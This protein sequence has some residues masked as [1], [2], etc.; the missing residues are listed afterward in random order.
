[1]NQ[2]SA[3]AHISVISDEK[4]LKQIHS[5]SEYISTFLCR[6]ATHEQMKQDLTNP[7]L[8]GGVKF[9]FQIDPRTTGIVLCYDKHPSEWNVKAIMDAIRDMEHIFFV[10]EGVI[11]WAG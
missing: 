1:M 8:L 6:K 7:T 5:L 2:Q 4:L 10:Q 11:F 3:A 9:W